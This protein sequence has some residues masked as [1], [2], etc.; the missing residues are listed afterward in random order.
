MTIL[1]VSKEGEGADLSVGKPEYSSLKDV[2]DSLNIVLRCEKG[3]PVGII[4][5]FD[6]AERASRYA[7]DTLKKVE[8]NPDV[9]TYI[10]GNAGELKK[11]S[12]ESL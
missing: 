11:R 10:G 9:I 2:P 5:G 4:V 8:L 12:V 3:E 1:F 6:S 7:E